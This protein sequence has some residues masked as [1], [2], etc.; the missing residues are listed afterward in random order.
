[1]THSA[2]IIARVRTLARGESGRELAE[3]ALEMA[4]EYERAVAWMLENEKTIH[5]CRKILEEIRRP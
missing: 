4:D 3:A 1:M 2:A 5:D